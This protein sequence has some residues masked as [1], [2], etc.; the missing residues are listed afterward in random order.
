LHFNDTKIAGCGIDA[1]FGKRN[2]QNVDAD[3]R[4]Y[5]NQQFRLYKDPASGNWAIAH[6]PEAT[7][8]TVLNGNKLDAPT[9]LAEGM[10]IAVGNTSR[11]VIKCPLTVRLV[12]S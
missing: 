3:G 5:D 12:Q 8:E 11:G 9:M 10:E 6:L 7:N 2:F 1:T 4:F